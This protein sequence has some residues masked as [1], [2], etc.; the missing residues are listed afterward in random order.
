MSGALKLFRSLSLFPKGIGLC[1]L[2]ELSCAIS[3]GADDFGNSH[4]IILK[5]HL[6]RVKK[7]NLMTVISLML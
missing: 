6:S 5:T 4:S 2:C 1:I 7:L 3:T